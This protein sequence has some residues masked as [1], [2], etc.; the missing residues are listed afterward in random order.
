MKPPITECPHC[1][2]DD[3]FYIKS[4]MHGRSRSDFNFCNGE[5][6]HNEEMYDNLSIK[7]GKYAYCGQCNKRLF[8]MS[9]DE[10]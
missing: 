7:Q 8:E 5:P 10:D 3:T 6:D 4:Y 2:N 1:G 9:Y